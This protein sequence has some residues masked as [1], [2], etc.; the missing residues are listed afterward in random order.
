MNLLREYIRE[1]LAEKE[2]RGAKTKRTLYHI[3]KRPAT[4]QPKM[5]YLQMWDRDATDPDTGERTGDM[6]TVP[7]TDVWERHWL[8]NPVKSGV[9]LTPNP[10]DIAM[11]HGRSGNVYAY[12]VPEWVINKS[13]GIHRYDNGSE[14]LIPEDVWNEA[15]DEIEFLGKSMDRNELWD[16]IDDSSFGR[17][18]TR[19]PTR[20]SWLSDEQMADWEER[21]NAFNLSGL[22]AT[23]HPEDVI[24]M[25]TAE[26]QRKAIEA[27]ESVAGTVSAFTVKDEELLSLLKKHLKESYLRETIRGLLRESIDPKIMS[28]IDRAEDAGFRVRIKPGYAAVYDPTIDIS[29]YTDAGHKNYVGTKNRVAG[30][31]WNPDPGNFGLPCSGARAV[32]VSGSKDFGMGPLAYDLA[33]EASGGLMSDRISVSPDAI[34]VWDYYMNNRP[35]VQVDQLDINSRHGLPQLTPDDPQDDCSQAQAIELYYSD[36]DKSSISKK[37]SKKGTP[38]MDELRRRGML[39]E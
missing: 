8:D 36:W 31:S 3:N 7:G 38:V 1:L 11:F 22:R 12:K 5:T 35:D 19:K 4:P 16:Q 9:F 14:V 32:S 30:V 37:L 23:R 28:M 29:S 13:G 34:A 27:I 33:I 39:D 25:L 15:G 18:R 26:E 2:T 10:V 17:G 21:Q 24:K 6:V 20:P